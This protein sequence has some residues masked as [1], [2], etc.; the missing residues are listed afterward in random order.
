MAD[1]R[2][3]ALGY[4][5]GIVC[6][7]DG[8]KGRPGASYPGASQF[9]AYGGLTCFLTD[10]LTRDGIFEA[11]RSRRHYGTTG[12]RIHLEVRVSLPGGARRYRRDP[13]HFDTPS[14]ET[15]TL[16]MG[17]IAQTDAGTATLHVAAAA[18]GPIERIDILNGPQIVA[19][20]RG[21]GE[22]DLGRRIRVL[23][24]GAEYRGRGRQTRWLGSAT[25]SGAAV[26][27]FQLINAWN[28]ERRFDLINDDT[29][30]WDAITT[31]NFGGFDAW[32]DEGPGATLAIRT[33]LVDATL[34][35]AEVG[36]D[37][38]IFAAGGLERRIVVYRLPEENPHRALDGAVQIP[39][40]PTG[41]NPLWVRVTTEEGHQA[42]SSPI[43]LYRSAAP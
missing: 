41:D 6:N 30:V 4:R 17:D 8:H 15:D 32:L 39:L 33:N 11:M 13:R 1:P 19:T 37:D 24:G 23:W 12:D 7:S 25:F 18:R 27:R 40:A 5:V 10:D 14:E 35:L 16:L 22:P 2:R 26:R 36:L 34:P 29:L 38:T 3:F 43:Y 20:L 21:Y 42:W 31:G 28:P 9:G